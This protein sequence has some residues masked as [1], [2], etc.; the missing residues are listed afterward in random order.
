MRA[1]SC[2]GVSCSILV[3]P[4]HCYNGGTVRKLLEKRDK[5]G[6]WLQK[7]LLVEPKYVSTI[8]Q[9]ITLCEVLIRL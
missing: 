9:T 8:C 7:L 3:R 4:V 5:C 1:S 2:Y 6:A